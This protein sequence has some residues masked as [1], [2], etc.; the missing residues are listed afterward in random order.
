M[1][2]PHSNPFPWI[3]NLQLQATTTVPDGLNNQS[4]E[5]RQVCQTEGV[6]GHHH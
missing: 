2:D 5:T 4:H 3:C 6:V 1:P